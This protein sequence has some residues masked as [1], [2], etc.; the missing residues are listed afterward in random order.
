[1]EYAYQ[2]LTDLPEGC[3][4]PAERTKPLGTVQALLSAK[5]LIHEPFAV[6]NAD[7]YYGV[8]GYGIMVEHLG[9]LAPEKQACIVGYYLKNAVSENGHVTRGVCSDRRAQ[10]SGQR[11]RDLQDQALP[12]RHQFATPR[13]TKTA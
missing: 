4:V 2:E 6:I 1:M 3:T 5:E 7:D 9:K 11:H 8:P 12:G 10:P 13:T